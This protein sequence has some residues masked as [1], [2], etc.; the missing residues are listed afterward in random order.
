MSLMIGENPMTP[1]LPHDL[2]QAVHQLGGTQ[3]LRVVDPDTSTEYVLLRADVFEKVQAV[4]HEDEADLAE[5][6]SA[7]SEAAS[8]AGWDEPEMADYDHYDENR[9]KLCP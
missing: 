8:S 3:P 4:L 5:T 2:R 9:K 1:E 6:Y 7:Q